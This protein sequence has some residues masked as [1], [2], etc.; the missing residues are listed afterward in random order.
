[1]SP[2]KQTVEPSATPIAPTPSPETAKSTI[3]LKRICTELKIDPKLARRKL[4]K[5]GLAFHTKRE[6]WEVEAG[7][8]AETAIRN[9]LNPPK[10]N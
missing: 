8:D 6:R 4:R 10:A 3:P 1:M 9:C 2:T 5:A 7:S